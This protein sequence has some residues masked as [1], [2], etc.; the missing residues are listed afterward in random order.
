MKLMSKVRRMGVVGAC[1]LS[2]AFVSAALPAGGNEVSGKYSVQ[3]TN[4]RGQDIAV[5]LRIT[6]TS[7]ADSP[8]DSAGVALRSLLSGTSEEIAATF[9]IPAGGNAEFMATV[10]ISQAEYKLWLGGERP[11]LALKLKT[12]DGAQISRTVALSPAVNAEAR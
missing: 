2:F 7:T 11:I 5:T 1:L 6:L 10:T 4:D 3:Q 12:Q 8:L 9:R